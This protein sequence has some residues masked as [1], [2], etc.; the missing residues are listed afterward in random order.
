MGCFSF[1]ELLFCLD[2]AALCK[3]QRKEGG[4]LALLEHQED[5]RVPAVEVLPNEKGI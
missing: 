3:D 2:A 5:N 4:P 1:K